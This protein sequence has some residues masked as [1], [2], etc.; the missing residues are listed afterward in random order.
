MRN[1]KINRKTSETAIDLDLTIDGSGSSSINTG[2][3]F[4]DHM[5]ILMTKHGLFDLEVT[6]NGDLEVD[7][8]HSVEDIGI[9]LG[10]AFNQA[11]GEKEGINRY[12]T[13]TSPMDEALA[14]VSLDISG[15]AYLVYHVEGLKDKVGSF[16]TELVEEFFQAFAS[17]A[18]VTLH[19]N[20]TYGKN[21]HHIIEAIFKGFGR[22][23]DQA[24]MKN[25]RIKGVPSTKGSL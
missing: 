9:A 16:D 5:L 11:L 4:F 1:Y 7:Q 21:T 13:V 25:P 22:A 18:K 8:H 15:R 17:N 20:L 12:A 6:C 3:G 14:N 10:Q 19:I 24:S 23:L 2:I